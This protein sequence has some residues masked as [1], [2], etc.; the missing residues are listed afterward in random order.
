MLNF[1]SKRGSSIVVYCISLTVLLA[2]SALVADIGVMVVEKNKLVNAV[3]AS[4]LAGAQELIYNP[5]LAEAKVR[6][7]I[8][9]NGVDPSAIQIDVNNSQTGLRVTAE[10]EVK[11]FLA[12]LLGFHSANVSST[13]SASVL[14]VS[15]VSGAR[16]FGIED[17]ELIFGE[18]YVLKSGSGNSG[19]FGPIELGGSGAHVYYNNIVDG[20]SG[21]LFV[22]DIIQTEPGNMSG[23]TEQGVETIILDC[24]HYPACTPDDFEPDC[25]RVIT[26]VII[27]TL[28]VS[29][30]ADV[31][32][33]GFASFFV[34]GVAGSGNE[35]FVTGKFIRSVTSGEI[36]ETQGDYGLYGVKLME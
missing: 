34:E 24:I 8:A 16:P 17:Q 19:N 32:I 4:V 29:G 14:P 31:T 28:N 13:A 7:Y 12:P 30:R 18:T 36:S 9:K 20:Y 23:P 21:R 22:G 3:D 10:K 1:K 33:V 25:A 2:I 5:T 15:G 26:V 6:D 27:D 35:S 11:F